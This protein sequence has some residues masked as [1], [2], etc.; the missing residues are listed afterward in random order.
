MAVEAMR[1]GEIIAGEQMEKRS[2][3]FS[4]L[5][6]ENKDDSALKVWGAIISYLLWRL[7]RRV[8]LSFT[9]LSLTLTRIPRSLDPLSTS[10]LIRPGSSHV[11]NSAN[12]MFHWKFAFFFFPPTKVARNKKLACMKAAV[13]S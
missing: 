2:T 4:E 11:T 13:V 7:S 8:I 9:S 3:D 1:L 12:Q 6:Q 10:P 5:L